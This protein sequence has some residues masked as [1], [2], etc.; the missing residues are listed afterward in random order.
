M[1]QIWAKLLKRRWKPYDVSL[2]KK[3]LRNLCH[4]CETSKRNK[5]PLCGKIEKRED[6]IATAQNEK[7][8]GY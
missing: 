7:D 1:E 4:W 3:V 8:T 2:V 5:T 6:T